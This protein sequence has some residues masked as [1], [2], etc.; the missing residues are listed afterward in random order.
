MN[1]KLSMVWLMS[2]ACLVSGCSEQSVEA[3]PA[4]TPEYAEL[5]QL[6]QVKNA[7]DDVT[8]GVAQLKQQEGS[9]QAQLKTVDNAL[10]H[11]EQTVTTAENHLGTLRADLTSL[12]KKIEAFESVKSRLE[13]L[14]NQ[15]KL[16]A[17]AATQPTPTIVK[18]TYRA[19]RYSFPYQVS[20]IDRWGDAHY[21]GVMT[22]GGVQMVQVGSVINQWV[23]SSVNMQQMQVTFIHQR[24]GQ[25]VKR[26]VK[27]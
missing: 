12:S 4:P 5:S 6:T 16:H 7:L 1:Y 15:E 24:N 19:P 18:K 17:K 23:V 2:S 25:R 8:V 13:A 26:S 20:A 27:L 10:Q 3:N 21:V 11:L 9:H 22:P 14:E